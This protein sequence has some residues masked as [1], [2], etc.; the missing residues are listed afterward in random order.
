MKA[1]KRMEQRCH[2]KSLAPTQHVTSFYGKEQV[3]QIPHRLVLSPAPRKPKAV[4]FA[5]LQTLG[6]KSPP[7]LLQIPERCRNRRST[8]GDPSAKGR[9]HRLD[10]PSR[11][12]DLAAKWRYKER[13][14]EISHTFFCFGLSSWCIHLNRNQL[15]SFSLIQYLQER[16]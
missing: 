7:A 13:P 11:L 16:L 10:F 1:Q 9:K 6:G 5:A 4:D 12:G 2:F 3:E 14:L 15:F 8:R